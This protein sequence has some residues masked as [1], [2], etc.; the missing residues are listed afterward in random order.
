MVSIRFDLVILNKS[1]KYKYKGTRSAA[2]N[3]NI[4]TTQ[5]DNEDDDEEEA[6]RTPLAN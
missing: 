4:V 1:V 2:I 3:A 5:E 6:P